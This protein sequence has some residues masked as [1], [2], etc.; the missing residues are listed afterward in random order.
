MNIL[1]TASKKIKFIF[2]VMT[3]IHFLRGYIDF[4]GY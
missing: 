4:L 2:L 3:K 1:I